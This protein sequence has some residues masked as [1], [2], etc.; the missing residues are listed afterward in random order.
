MENIANQ[1]VQIADEEVLETIKEN[2]EGNGILLKQEAQKFLNN[3]ENI[4]NKIQNINL[5]EKSIYRIKNQINSGQGDEALLQEELSQYRKQ[6]LSDV[7]FQK[8][9]NE[10]LNFQ[11]KLNEFLGQK[12]KIIY[13]YVSPNGKTVKLFELDNSA[14]HIMQSY[15]SKG[16]GF[17]P[18]YKN[19][20]QKQKD[21][22]ED[23]PILQG[24]KAAHSAAIWR[25]RY[26]KKK[27]QSSNILLLW[28]PLGDWKQMWISSEGDINES[29]AAFYLRNE[30]NP[31]F[32]SSKNIEVLLDVFLTSHPSGV[33]YVDNVSGLLEG[34][35]SLNNIEYAIKSKGASSLGYNQI[36]NLA[37]TIA[38]MDELQITVDFLKDIKEQLYKAGKTRN[39][40]LE[41][42]LINEREEIL[43]E[44]KETFEKS[45]DLTLNL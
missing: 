13:V 42:V 14:N 8:F 38:Q 32:E 27:R 6:R 12:I 25:A 37:N 29:Y 3:I 36:I 33:L 9:T 1:A 15:A 30:P 23:I 31:T 24:L 34:D 26:G 45:L 35:V 11:N 2:I 41:N 5:I 40:I 43:Q 16:G 17:K 7:E 10:I 22:T 4:Y 21:I 19:L 28:K 44:L 39:K 18:R 20:N